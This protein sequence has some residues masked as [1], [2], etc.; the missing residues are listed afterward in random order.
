[1]LDTCTTVVARG[2]LY[3]LDNAGRIVGYS[4]GGVVTVLVVGAALV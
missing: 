2:M 4:I 3:I 1:M